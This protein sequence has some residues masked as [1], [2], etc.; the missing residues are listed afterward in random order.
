MCKKDDSLV[1]NR[2]Y[3]IIKA[4][5]DQNIL[6]SK[7]VYKLKQ[8]LVG[9]VLQYKAHQVIYGF[10]Q[11]YGVDYNKTYTSIVKLMSYQTLFIIT[12]IQGWQIH[13][14]DIKTVF[15]YGDINKK[16][17]V[18]LLTS[19]GYNLLKVAHLNKTLYRL[20]Q[21]PH[22]WFSN[23][24]CFLESQGFQQYQYNSSVFISDNL[25]VRVYINNLLILGLELK[26]IK[27]LKVVLSKKYQ[28]QDLSQAS[29]YLGIKVIRDF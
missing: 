24:S 27:V 17:F 8:G 1:E 10:K 3:I 22:I 25:I 14:I 20:K 11:K 15:L 13:Q 16:I 9:E 26:K 2:I 5:L 19:L 7:Q 18:K 29:F 28:I 6:H 23:I 12:N 4:L 21:S